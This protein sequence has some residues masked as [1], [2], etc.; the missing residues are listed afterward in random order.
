M[1]QVGSSDMYTGC[2]GESA[3]VMAGFLNDISRPVDIPSATNVVN[4]NSQYFVRGRRRDNSFGVVIEH[5]RNRG[6]IPSRDERYRFLAPR[7]TVQT[8]PASS[9]LDTE[10][11]VKRSG[12][13]AYLH[14]TPRFK[15]EWS[16]TSI[17][18]Y[19]C[20]GI[21]LPSPCERVILW[22]TCCLGYKEKILTREIKVRAA[23]HTHLQTFCHVL[24]GLR[25][26]FRWSL[27]MHTSVSVCSFS[28]TSLTIPVGDVKESANRELQHKG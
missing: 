5:P 11:R 6:S 17:A 22:A 13:E 8:H 28:A 16:Y 24:Q 18:T 10:G 15:N 12:R 21:A 9:S 26:K 2:D 7:L 25:I 4:F 20:A 19:A 14:L 1:V 23:R 27:Y 3:V